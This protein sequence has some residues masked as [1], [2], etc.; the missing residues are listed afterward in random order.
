M[1]NDVWVWF[2]EN[3]KTDNGTWGP[4]STRF[5]CEGAGANH[6]GPEYGFGFKMA[7]E[8][9]E[10]ILIIKTAWGGKTLAGDFR[11]PSSCN[12]PATNPKNRTVGY[13][14]T[15]MLAMVQETLSPANVTKYFP[16]SKGVSGFDIVGFGWDQGWNDGCSTDDAG[17]YEFNMVN[18]VKDLRAAWGSPALAVSIPVSGFGGWGQKNERRLAVIAA[19]FGAANATRHPEL[20]G[21]VAAEETRSFWR[22]PFFSP[23]NQAY[24]W[25]HNAE[26][27]WLIGQAMGKGMLQAMK[28]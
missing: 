1:R 21:H 27:Y 15:R 14:Y 2:N 12:D 23:S 22:D 5:G 3:G 10:Q 25:G 18:L 24:H 11:P 17:E 13:Y 28:A 6:I 7:D 9:A 26:S 8:L 16:R 19:Q 4:L 20:G